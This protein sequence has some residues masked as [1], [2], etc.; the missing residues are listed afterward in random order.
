MFTPLSRKKN[1]TIST[2]CPMCHRQITVTDI[3]SLPQARYWKRE[4]L[5]YF[6]C[7]NIE[8]AVYV[9]LPEGGD[10]SAYLVVEPEN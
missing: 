10:I 7:C 1:N 9:H 2:T 3:D 4:N 8:M 5:Q 6:D